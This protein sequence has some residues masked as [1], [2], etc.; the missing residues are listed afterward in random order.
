MGLDHNDLGKGQLLCLWH[1][2]GQRTAKDHFLSTKE[3]LRVHCCD[4][5]GLM[6]VWLDVP[7]TCPGAGRKTTFE[8]FGTEWRKKLFLRIRNHKPA[9][10]WFAA[11]VHNTWV[12]QRSSTWK[13]SL[14]WLWVGN[15]LRYL[16][17]VSRNPFWGNLPSSQ[18]TK[19]S[20][21]QSHFK[22]FESTVKIALHTRKQHSMNNTQMKNKKI[23]CSN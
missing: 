20:P 2:R 10:T 4:S 11:Q 22:G 14:E 15:I 16:T 21:K 8:K 13:F 1:S 9:L 12:V 3:I 7:P 23:K 17:E 19:N 18:I 6:S 5:K